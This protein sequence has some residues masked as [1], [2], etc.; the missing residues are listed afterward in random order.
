[1]V[2]IAAPINEH[3]LHFKTATSPDGPDGPDSRLPERG[4]LQKILGFII[5]HHVQWVM[6]RWWFHHRNH[7]TCGF[8]IP[9]FEEI[10]TAS[11]G[12]LIFAADQ[13]ILEASWTSLRGLRER[14]DAPSRHPETR[15]KPWIYHHLYSKYLASRNHPETIWKPSTIPQLEIRCPE[16]I[17][18]KFTSLLYQLPSGYD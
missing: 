4:F 16:N 13:R 8:L 2:R 18:V 10:L 3:L 15:Q 11:N 6:I 7:Q 12:F 1:M 5:S 14:F 9:G 17:N